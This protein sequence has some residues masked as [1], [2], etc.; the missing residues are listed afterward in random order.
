M[1]FRVVMIGCN[2]NRTRY[3]TCQCVNFPS[4]EIDATSEHVWLSP[5][6]D[7]IYTLPLPEYIK[8]NDVLAFDFVLAC[9]MSCASL[10]NSRSAWYS[11]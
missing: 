3:R 4:R 10:L 5:T 9:V 7:G 1:G 2:S 8:I 6:K 11:K